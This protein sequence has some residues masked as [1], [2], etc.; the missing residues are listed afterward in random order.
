MKFVKLIN[1]GKGYFWK[2]FSSPD[3]NV[4]GEFFASDYVPNEWDEWLV[5]SKTD[6]D[7]VGSNITQIEKDKNGNVFIKDV[8]NK[9]FC[10]FKTTKEKI[11]KLFHQWNTIIQLHPKEIII[12]ISDHD[13]ITI[14][15]INKFFVF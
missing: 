13:D 14:E 12:T 9:E 6:G 11:L 5:D 10:T 2:E 1:N 7:I 15:A 8:F 3:M 4:L